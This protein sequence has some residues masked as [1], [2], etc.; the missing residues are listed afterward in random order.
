[1]QNVRIQLD[2]FSISSMNWDATLCVRRDLVD[3]AGYIRDCP[4]V[5][6]QEIVWLENCIE[7]GDQAATI[8]QEKS[9]RRMANA[10]EMCTSANSYTAPNVGTSRG[11]RR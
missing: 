5:C 11:T 7:R 4:M 1:M 2:F 10:T 9:Q 8:S 3:L 6:T